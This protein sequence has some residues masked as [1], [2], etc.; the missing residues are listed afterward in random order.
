M[1]KTQNLPM[2]TNNKLP[3]EKKRKINRIKE[4][5]KRA[6]RIALDTGVSLAGITLSAIGG[7]IT[8][9]IGMAT[10]VVSL[11][12]AGK[13]II[14]KKPNKDSMFVTRNN[15]K[16]E[17]TLSQ[18]VTS[19]KAFQKMKGLKSH[20]KAALMGIEMLV[21]IQ[22][23]KQQFADQNKNKENNTY[24]HIF[25]TTTHG[26]NIKTIEALEKLGYIDIVE[27]EPA[28]KSLLLLEKLQFKQYKEI[29]QTLKAQLKFDK[30]TLES[31]K[32][33]MY[34]LKFKLTD[35]P[36]DL[37]ELYKQYIENKSVRGNVAQKR[38][39][40]ILDALKDQ[41]IDIKINE[42]GMSQIDY[43]SQQS[44]ARRIRREVEIKNNVK[45]FKESNKVNI[46]S[47]YKEE[48]KKDKENNIEMENNDKKVEEDQLIM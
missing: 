2:L 4:G 13:E 5:M 48:N 28:N 11:T 25:K 16:R 34:A 23:Y 32:K 14:Y 38:V 39:G 3:I 15:L 19:I 18:D 36:L 26:I 22:N 42:L 33:Q 12:K 29:G 37:E 20:E 7:P 46:D 30:E 40:L 8:S 47:Q 43:N 35:K 41:K 24:S 45:K 9:T 21:G 44:I 1:D 17:T 10:F 31:Q 6:G 27:K